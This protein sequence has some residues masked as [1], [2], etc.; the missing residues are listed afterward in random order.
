MEGKCPKH[1]SFPF[2]NVEELDSWER[3]VI[4]RKLYSESLEMKLEFKKL[5][6]KTRL[7][8]KNST[9]SPHDVKTDVLS[10]LH[11]EEF[12][13]KFDAAQTFEDIFKVLW[14]SSSW[15]WFHFDVLEQLIK[16]YS[17]PE[18]D[19]KIYQNHF[20][21]YCERR[22]YECP[23]PIE[24]GHSSHDKELFLLITKF[25]TD[26]HNEKLLGLKT[27]EQKIGYIIKAKKVFKVATI[28]NGCTEVY[29]TLPRALA[30]EVFPLTP[31]QEEQLAECGVLQYYIYP[32]P[33]K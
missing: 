6:S 12:Q 2:L 26:L 5:A 3:Q 30:K 7:W 25:Q 33:G 11:L 31:K 10:D 4:E 22:T 16:F 20:E 17:I 29:F 28:K 24:E 9:H 32:D 15:S 21:H 13:E 14:K 18:N 19:L 27:I 8:L 1:E 23:L